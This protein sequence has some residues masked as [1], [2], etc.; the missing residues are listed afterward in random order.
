[1]AHARASDAARGFADGAQQPNKFEESKTRND[2]RDFPAAQFPAAHFETARP[3]SGR[4]RAR[5]GVSTA[6]YDFL[7][8]KDCLRLPDSESDKVVHVM[9]HRGCNENQTI[10]PVENAAMTW[11]KFG[12][13]LEA[14]IAFDRG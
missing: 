13:V 2:V 4:Y 10:E 14:E 7:S 9:K 8:V 11:N 6:A 5:A 3:E 12:R 1:M